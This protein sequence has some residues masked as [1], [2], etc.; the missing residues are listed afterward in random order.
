MLY[1]YLSFYSMCYV[2]RYF[3][4]IAIISDVYLNTGLVMAFPHIPRA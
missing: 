3:K 2:L 4:A 1:M